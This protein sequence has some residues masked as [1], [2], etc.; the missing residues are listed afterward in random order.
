MEHSLII[1]GIHKIVKKFGNVL[2]G[3]QIC[4]HDQGLTNQKDCRDTSPWDYLIYHEPIYYDSWAYC[5][6]NSFENGW[7]STTRNLGCIPHGSRG[8]DDQ[9][10]W[11]PKY[12]KHDRS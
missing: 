4:S 5:C 7:T 1:N 2:I 12:N 3:C 8:A 9:A 6:S 10:T 11:H